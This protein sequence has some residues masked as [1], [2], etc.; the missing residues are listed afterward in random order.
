MNYNLLDEPWIPVLS[1][2]GHF[3]RWGL[4]DVLK[5]TDRVQQ[6]A[7]SNPMDRV[8]LLRLFL[9]ILYWTR[10]NPPEA[11]RA[12]PTELFPVATL[13]PLN[14]RRESFNLLGDDKRFYQFHTLGA[15]VDSGSAAGYLIHEVPT[16]TNPWHFRH[17]TDNQDGLCPACCAMGL[18]RLPA[19]TTIGG[20][21]WTTGVNG[22]PPI[23]AIPKGATLGETLA[24]SWRPVPSLG[25][26]AWIEPD[27]GLP[28]EGEIPILTGLTWLPWRVWLGEPGSEALVC[29]NCGRQ[30]PTIRR[31]VRAQTQKPA[32]VGQ[33]PWQDPHAV[34]NPRPLTATHPVR[35]PAAVTEQ[36]VKV[37]TQ[38]R[39][40]GEFGR[41]PNS[42][43]EVVALAS[44]KAH[45]LDIVDFCLPAKEVSDSGAGVDAV[46]LRW[47]KSLDQ[48]RRE[49][50]AQRWGGGP[51]LA[52]VLPQVLNI[53]A[54]DASDS[55]MG[56]GTAAQG[57]PT[58]SRFLIESIAR[59]FAPDPTVTA[60]RRRR[61]AQAALL[62]GWA[63]GTVSRRRGG[64]RTSTRS[65]SGS[66][67]R[68]RGRMGSADR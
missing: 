10:G 15:E 67:D 50:M 25:V 1:N 42:A 16:G 11:D 29:A 53:V 13:T 21:G 20:R 3:H 36:W 66:K 46:H 34:G 57:I 40:N 62:A 23:Y 55:I 65:A 35:Y 5:Q 59:S 18:V 33:P 9:A 58:E 27:A 37:R 61:D 44:D 49:L 39:Q 47:R 14:E 19:F 63:G 32:R 24:R 4:L 26:P 43:V 12:Q 41:W 22:T 38:I 30:G 8:A 56:G 64:R 51:R 28:K 7:S 2:D 17:T 68:L 45:C 60:A 6:F 31:C 52:A 48:Y 54:S